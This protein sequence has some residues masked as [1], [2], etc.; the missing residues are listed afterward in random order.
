MRGLFLAAV[1][2]A[3]LGGCARDPAPAAAITPEPAAAPQRSTT[4]VEGSAELA[5]PTAPVATPASSRPGAQALA[6]ATP[7]AATSTDA[8]TRSIPLAI[9]GMT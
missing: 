6:S 9:T 1:T 7:V 5:R 2:I 4:T 3:A 8:P